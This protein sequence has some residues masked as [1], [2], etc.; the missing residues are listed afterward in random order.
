MGSIVYRWQS[1]TDGSSWNNIDGA[2]AGRFT[3]TQAQVGQQL[4]VVASYVDA[5]GTAESL[6]SAATAAIANVNDA[7]TI[8]HAIADQAATEDA[9]FSF[10]LP[11]D[12]FADI[13]A[14]DSLNYAATLADGAALPSWLSFD[15]A[16]RRFSGTP[17]RD[18]VG[19]LSLRVTATDLAGASAANHFTLSV[20]SSNHAPVL[21]AAIGD[22]SATQYIGFSYRVPAGSFVD[23]DP[24]DSL[25]FV[26]TLADGTALPTWLS[27][28]AATRGFSGTPGTG[29]PGVLALRV[30]ATDT[31]GLSAQADFKL[32]VGQHLHGTSSGDT[33]NY[34]AISFV[35]VPLLDGGAGNDTITGSAGNDLILGGTGTDNLIGGAG[36]DRFLISGT[37]SAYDRFE[38]D[39]GYDVVQG[40]AGDDRI[41]LYQY[42]GVATVEKIDGGGGNDIVAGTGNYDTLDFSATE[43]VGIAMIDGGA[44]NDTIT[45]SAGNDII[46]GGS[47]TDRLAG[48]AGNDIYRLGRGDGAETLV[49]NDATPGNT[50]AAQFLAGIAAEQVWFRHVGNTLEASIIG[51]GDSLTIEN[52]YLGSAHHVEQFRTADNKLLLDSRVELLIQAMAAF[53]PPAAGQTSLPPSYQDSLAPVIA[54]NWQ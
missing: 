17:S 16:T 15:A 51:T 38:G 30:T 35:G 8:A 31:A 27:F 10:T 22:Q 19:S 18:A 32:A 33:L 12:S 46:V 41:R 24:G 9:V 50:D 28:D 43:L 54:A 25:S 1:S 20:A 6:P 2:T 29:T 7:P 13:D 4:R 5:Q 36:D 11:A 37:D 39:A 14:R 45:G 21:A 26:A 3:L 49:E 53:A 23:S 40:S 34:S 52:W 44:G 42:T 48:G 47:G